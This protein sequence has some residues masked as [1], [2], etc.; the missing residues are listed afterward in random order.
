MSE[1]ACFHLWMLMY[2]VCGCWL[3]AW[4]V[5]GRDWDMESS[6]ESFGRCIECIW[7][8]VAGNFSCI[9]LWLKYNDLNVMLYWTLIV[10][11]INEADGAFYG[12][13]IDIQV[14]DALK[15]KFQ[16]GTLQVLGFSPSWRV[17]IVQANSIEI[18]IRVFCKHFPIYAIIV[19]WNW[20]F[21]LLSSFL[22]LPSWISNCPKGLSCH[23]Q[24]KTR[25]NEIGLLWSTEQF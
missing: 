23:I 7:K 3:E 11:Q 21:W 18:Y 17:R 14:F 25:L 8:A 16:C 22:F 13:K 6:R 12:P 1:S 10:G 4:E 20:G 9:R 19:G 2:W 24:Q 5:L 15:R